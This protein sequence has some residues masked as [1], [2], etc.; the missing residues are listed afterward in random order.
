MRFYDLAVARVLIFGCGFTGTRV[1][2]KLAKKGYPVTATSRHP[3]LLWSLP[4]WPIGFEAGNE[5]VLRRIASKVTSDTGVLYSIPPV[6][7]PL[8]MEHVTNVAAQASRLVYLSTTGVYGDQREVNE[9]TPVR[10]QNYRGIERVEAENAAAAIYGPGRGVHAS[11][12][13]GKFQLFGDGSNQVSRIH[14]DDL[15]EHCVAAL[16]SEA[17]GAWPVADEEPCT[18]LEIAKFCQQFMGVREPLQFGGNDP[19]ETRGTD[20]WVDGRAIRR[21]LGIGLKYPTYRSGIPACVDEER[22]F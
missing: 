14:V 22:A 9:N 7:I 8:F 2:L 4:V 21:I 12:A 1:A 3:D 11:L 20:R 18:S 10:P 5:E 19:G 16:E 13:S 17:I 6:P 15:A